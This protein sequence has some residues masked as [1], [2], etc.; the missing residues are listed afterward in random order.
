M[1]TDKAAKEAERAKYCAQGGPTYELLKKIDTQIGVNP[2]SDFAVGDS[3]TIADLFIHCQCNSLTSG[4]YDG[5]PSTTL[6]PFH[7][8]M[9]LRKAVRSHP[10]VMKWYKE[11]EDANVT[12][13]PSYG[14]L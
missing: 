12:V 6:E 5:V 13:P 10:G 7:H 3:L 11:L 2:D 8:I 1:G 9:A 14:L 4:L